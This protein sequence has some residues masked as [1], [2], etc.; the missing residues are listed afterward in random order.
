[1]YMKK[2][3][4]IVAFYILS[5]IIAIFSQQVYAAPFWY[6]PDTFEVKINNIKEKD[7]ENIEVE[8]N[9]QALSFICYVDTASLN[10]GNINNN[11]TQER[12]T[13]MAI[14]NIGLDINSDGWEKAK[15]GE[16]IVDDINHIT[17]MVKCK[18]SK[19]QY[20]KNSVSLII[21]DINDIYGSPVCLK[22][23]MKN[24]DIIYSNMFDYSGIV[25][26][27]D[28]YQKAVKDAKELTKKIGYF[29][30]DYNKEKNEINVSFIG[31]NDEY[32]NKTD[33]LKMNIIKIIV[34][35]V[36]IILILILLCM[37]LIK[38]NIRKSAEDRK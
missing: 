31:L 28:N 20:L 10:Y 9:L 35:I 3:K 16:W 1:M 15:N 22:I 7:I 11:E 19:P 33:N 26:D 29:E 38:R 8:Y 32:V 14:E 30:G 6:Y 34:P 12:L 21:Y 13:Q 24:G 17:R 27:E 18:I 23:T 25:V 36:L 4:I 2:L 5:I 37:F